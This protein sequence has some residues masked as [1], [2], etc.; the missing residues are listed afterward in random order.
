MIAYKQIITLKKP[1]DLVEQGQLEGLNAD[2]G[3]I[4]VQDISLHELL[5]QCAESLVKHLNAAFARIWTLNSDENVL[6]L[7]A[8]AGMYTHLDGEHSRVPVGK[9]KIGLIAKE[10]LP[11]LTN[12]ILNDPRLSDKE[13]AK[14]EGMR[15]FAGYPLIVE[16]KLVGVMCVFAR[17]PLTEATLKAMASVSNGIAN[18][19]ERKR[20]ENICGR[21]KKNTA[22]SL[23]RHRMPVISIDEKSTILFINRAAEKIFGYEIGEMI[24][25]NLTMLMPEHLRKL[26]QAGLA[27]Y[28]NTGKRH[29]NWEHV[30]IPGLHRQGMKF[31]LNYP[32][33]NIK[34]TISIFISELPEIFPTANKPKHKFWNLSRNLQHWWMPFRNSS[35]WRKPTVLFSGIT[36]IGI[37]I[38]ERHPK[39]W[40]AGVGSRFMIPKY[41]RRSSNAG[42]YH[43][44]PEN[45]LKC[46]FL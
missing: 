29:L 12:D 24:G 38:P 33:A 32:S 43:L 7:Q 22:S 26:H 44:K 14:S 9:F 34:K 15:S 21:A 46:S 5:N 20:V 16:D 10:R 17:H 6:E 28:G 23:K 27:R 19:I 30:E 4:L 1:Y 8:S 13:W 3:N 11:H 45:L 35:G 2:I 25:Q 31:R 40:K 37:N 36:K 18:G 39:I 41:C 42:N